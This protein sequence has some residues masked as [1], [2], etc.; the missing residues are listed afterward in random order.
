M[1]CMGVYCS[2]EPLQYT[3][4]EPHKLPLLTLIFYISQALPSARYIYIPYRPIIIRVS[5]VILPLCV[6]V[7][8]FSFCFIT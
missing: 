7:C 3:A 4:T 8:V 1:R 2:F 5:I 6:G